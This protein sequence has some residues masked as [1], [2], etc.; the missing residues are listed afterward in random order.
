M[1]II[2]HR[3]T[4]KLPAD[5]LIHTFQTKDYNECDTQPATVT[6]VLLLKTKEVSHNS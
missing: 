4:E 5:F 2:M 3:E 6:D 1:S